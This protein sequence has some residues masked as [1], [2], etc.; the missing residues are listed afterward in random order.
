MLRDDGMV[1]GKCHGRI[2]GL[3]QLIV[4]D[5]EN[6]KTTSLSYALEKVVL[7]RIFEL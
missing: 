3:D 2:D 4:G 1:G 6:K 7:V 5:V